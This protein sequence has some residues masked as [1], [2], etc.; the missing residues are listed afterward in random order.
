MALHCTVLRQRNAR[1]GKGMILIFLGF[2]RCPEPQGDLEILSI[3]GEYILIK[4]VLRRRM[5]GKRP[6][7]LRNLGCTQA[8]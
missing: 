2:K 1:T 4:E 5:Q 6:G 3:E 8:K 7:P